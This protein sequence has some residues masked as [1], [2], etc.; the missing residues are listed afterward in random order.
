MNRCWCPGTGDISVLVI[1]TSNHR[2]QVGRNLQRSL[3]Q[4]SAPSRAN[5]R[6]RSRCSRPCPVNC[7]KSS[8]REIPPPPRALPQSTNTLPVKNFPHIQLDSPLVQTVPAGSHPF[9]GHS[10]QVS[11]SSSSAS[12]PWRMV[13]RS[14]FSLL[15]PRV[16]NTQ[17]FQ[18]LLRHASFQIFLHFSCLKSPCSTPVMEAI[19]LCLHKS[20]YFLNC[21]L[22]A[23]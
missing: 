8:K 13:V 11:G 1:K 23:A 14:L 9:A 6:V 3:V 10:W 7:R 12:P 20:Y 15:V 22:I 21:A 2:R 19:S 16:K 4:P 17:F 5:R 18:P